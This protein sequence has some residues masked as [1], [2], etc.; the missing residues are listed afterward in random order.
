MFLF[1]EYIVEQ[2]EWNRKFEFVTI[3]IIL[4]IIK[5]SIQ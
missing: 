2:E 3:Y 1:V 5:N 4:T